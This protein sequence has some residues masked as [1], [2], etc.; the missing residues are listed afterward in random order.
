MRRIEGGMKRKAGQYLGAVSLAVLAVGS[1]QAQTAE[2]PATATPTAAVEQDIVVTG[3]RASLDSALNVKREAIGVVDVIKAEDIAD[4]PDNNLAE[5]IQRIPGVAITRDQGEGRNITVRGLGPVFTRVRIN[6]MEGLSTTGGSDASG[7]ANRGRAFDFN[8]FA[9]ELFNS[10]TVRKTASADV[11]EGSLGATVDLETSRPFDY[12][13]DMTVAASAQVGLNDLSN[14]IDPKLS[15]LF[16][17]KL[18]DGRLGILVSAAYSERGIL[19]EGPSTVRWERSSDNGGFAP[20]STL[21]TGATAG[22]AFFHPRIP[23]Y[24]SYRYK[25]KRLGLTGSI[26][27]EPTDSTLLTFDALYADFKSDR[28]EQYLEALSFS[29]S[30]TGKPQTVILPGAVVD[31]TNSLVSGTFNNVDIRVE[32][33]FDKLETEF[34]QYTLSL[35]QDFGERVQLR[36]LGGYS[37]SAFDN[38]IQTT[39]TLDANNVQGYSYDFSN[40]RN[41]TFGYGNLNVQDP[42]AFTLSEIRLRPQFVDNE[43][44]IGR[45]ELEF[46]ASE[47]IRLK[48][49]FDYKK[50]NYASREYR[51]TSET[52]VP[53][54]APGQLAGLSDLYSF[55]PGTPMGGTVRTFVVP[56]IDAFADELGIYS[57]S[58]I[59]T[60]TGINNNSAQG[61]WTTVSERDLGG[62]LQA[63]YNGEIGGMPLK[64]DAGLR[65]VETKQSST[66]YV[67]GAANPQQIIANKTYDDWLPSANVGLEITDELILRAGIAKVMSR[68]NLNQLTPGGAFS[69]SGGN[70]TFTRGNPD[71][72]PTRAWD[73]DVSAEWYFA[74]SSVLSVAL[75]YK[76]ISSFVA[77][78]TQ[79]IPFNELGLPPSL[80][81]GTTVQPTDLFTV[82]QPIN[83]DG[84][85]VKGVEFGFQTLFNFLPGPL[86]NIGLQA[87]YTYVKSNI[88]YPLST[89]AGAPV[90]VQP[91]V[92]LSKHSANGTLYYEDSR[93]MLRGSVSYRSGFL[94]M[95]PGRNG[96]SP[97][98]GPN[99]NPNAGQPTFNDVEGTH[100]SIN[101]D[102]SASL[103][104][105]EN[106]SLTAEVINLTDEYVDQYIDS[107]ADRLSTYHHTGRQFYFGAR[108]KL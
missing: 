103:K 17:T 18:M 74:R 88:E 47:T 9:S 94:T 87:N 45:A 21:P 67:G 37:K 16:S 3:Y 39:V 80:L 19:E 30:G 97:G 86:S 105:T 26:Q 7:G 65:Y 11:E 66:G 25:T 28:A 13:D 5:S 73:Y 46:E 22:T 75:F 95:V 56:N 55:S 99:F 20:T 71:I 89:A 10:I 53:T 49:G 35:R 27:F 44:K 38:P 31:D 43:F 50:Y 106:V 40:G 72:G 12:S 6:G 24:D 15:A 77:N 54:L 29:R 104:V 2:A 62:Y 96:V 41:P 57:N 82:T 14:A 4:F 100:G 85:T 1:A 59:Y 102:L 93:F 107:A 69:I 91:L 98:N 76:D 79:Q 83:S 42:N 48:G 92:N 81:D 90:I 63:V 101:V 33:R 68:P 64:A 70:R 36:A 60:L 108:F 52:N 51:R 32:S 8:V 34:Q 58:G 23:R 78:T 84:G 61:N